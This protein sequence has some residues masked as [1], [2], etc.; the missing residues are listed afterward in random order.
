MTA[1]ASGSDTDVEKQEKLVARRLYRKLNAD[2]EKASRRRYYL[3]NKEK[4]LLRGLRFRLKNPGYAA[5]KNAE[6]YGKNLQFHRARA[7]SW[8]ANNP[9]KN[10]AK[11]SSARAARLQ[12]LPKWADRWAIKAVYALALRLQIT[13]GV[14]YHVDHIIPLRGKNVCGLHVHW[15]LQAIPAVKNLKKGNRLWL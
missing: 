12:A 11:T 9:E 1:T 3:R 6:H 4:V 5:K 10:R 2:K 7:A 13:T 14:I 15:N 8:A